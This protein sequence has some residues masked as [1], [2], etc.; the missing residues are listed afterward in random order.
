MKILSLT[1]HSVQE[2]ITVW[3]NYLQQE[4]SEMIDNLLDVEKYILSE[5]ESEMIQ[6][7]KNYNLLLVFENEEYR[8]QFLESELV[9]LEERIVQK[10]GNQVMLF[11]TFLNPKKSRL[12]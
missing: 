12:I 7:G 3:E 2:I 11:C 9:N 5:V 6:E 10:F 4:F 8:Q 1:F